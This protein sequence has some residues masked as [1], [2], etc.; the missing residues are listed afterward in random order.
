MRRKKRPVRRLRKRR[1]AP[2]T[3]QQKALD[4]QMGYEDGYRQGQEA[5]AGSYSI[6]FDGTSIIIPS[7]NQAEK[8]KAC[9]QSIA[10]HTDLPYE[11]I[12][13]DRGSTDDTDKL[14]KQMTGQIRYFIMEHGD[15]S[16]AAAINRGLMMAKGT[17]LLIMDSCAQAT[18][19]WLDQLLYGLSGCG[20]AG[21]V[22]PMSNGGSGRQRKLLAVEAPDETTYSTPNLFVP[23]NKW[24]ETDSLDSFCILFHRAL[25][26]NTGYWDERFTA[27]RF[28][29]EDYCY[30]V[31]LQGWR[32]LIAEDAYVVYNG[33]GGDGADSLESDQTEQVNRL[34]FQDKWS[35]NGPALRSDAE[36]A[37]AALEGKP[38]GETV[39]Y[40]QGIAVK[41]TGSSIYW[42]EG[43]K[44]HLIE[45]NWPYPVVQLSNIE[46]KR[47]QRGPSI[48][49]SI[50]RDPRSQMEGNAA[51]PQP[52]TVSYSPDGSCYYFE[53]GQKRKVLSRAASE[54]WLLYGRTHVS[55]VPQTME[56][57]PDGYPIIAPA[58]LRQSL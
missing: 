24:A 9:M 33:D 12:V 14:L 30:R 23:S 34:W 10:E 37:N 1:K 45:G 7:L 47:W 6:Y 54:A 13:V 38:A 3:N 4:Y 26:E 18:E 22:G 57:L 31:V 5:G 27:G 50:M 17:T 42:I 41:G 39:F 25:W 15:N 20:Q 19:Y 53:D 56:T 58:S 28:A 36:A 44:R 32:L 52:G 35:G 55:W 29:M 43:G 40:P 46:I 11:I 2:R 16:R 49:A 21:I 51:C 48:N 8:L